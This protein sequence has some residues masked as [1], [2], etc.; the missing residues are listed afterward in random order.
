MEY[1][2]YPYVSWNEIKKALRLKGS[3]SEMLDEMQ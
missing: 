2:E 3:F 1:G